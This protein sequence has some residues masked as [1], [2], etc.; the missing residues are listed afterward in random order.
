MGSRFCVIGKTTNTKKLTLKFKNNIV[1]EIPIDL[2]TS[3]API[4][5]RKFSKKIFSKS[6]IN[7]K[8]LKKIKIEESFLKFYHHLINQIKIG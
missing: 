7:L 1:G 3:K 2:L 8:K 5:E 4:Y 6:K